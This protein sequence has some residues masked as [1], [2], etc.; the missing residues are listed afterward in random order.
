MGAE[1]KLSPKALAQR[2]ADLAVRGAIKGLP[3]GTL[4]ALA[5]SGAE[6]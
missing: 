6:R 4:N 3:N 1:G 2:L 5:F